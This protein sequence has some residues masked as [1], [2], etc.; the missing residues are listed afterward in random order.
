MIRWITKITRA[1]HAMEKILNNIIPAFGEIWNMTAMIAI[2]KRRN[3]T[4]MYYL[5][6]NKL[7]HQRNVI[8]FSSS[9]IAL[10]SVMI[11][12][13][14]TIAIIRQENKTIPTNSTSVNANH[15]ITIV[16]MV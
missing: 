14:F 15:G 10:L 13:Y 7:L 11:L 8:F 5:L 9:S 16:F 2:T 3:I 12:K 1:I 6:M 4:I